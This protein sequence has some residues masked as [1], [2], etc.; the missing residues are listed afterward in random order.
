MKQSA[1]YRDLVGHWEEGTNT[2]AK[3]I[4]LTRTN[5]GPR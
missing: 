1:L 5:T 2:P 3:I 4:P